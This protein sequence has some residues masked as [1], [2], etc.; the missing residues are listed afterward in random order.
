MEPHYRE[1]LMLFL[2]WRNE[3]KDLYGG[4]SSYTEHYNAKKD[5]IMPVRLK[6]EKHN[7]SLQEAI[8]QV[9][10]A[11]Q[12]YDSTDSEEEDCTEKNQA[13]LGFFDPERP[14]E[15]TT[16]DIG[17]DIGCDPK[18]V[19]EHYEINA[20]MPETEYLQLMRSLN[21]QQSEI[22]IQVIQHLD[23]SEEQICLFLEGGAGVGKT[24]CA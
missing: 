1:C 3:E 20:C 24:Q 18:Y 17:T 23:M 14:E 8:E 19:T 2:P 10:A 22:C 9:S 16:H 7:D 13:D 4:Y 21:K 11:D 15:H 6:Y 5:D 12:T